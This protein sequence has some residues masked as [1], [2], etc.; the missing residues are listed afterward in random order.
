MPRFNSQ[1]KQIYS[2][3]R[4]KEEKVAESNWQQAVKA[5]GQRLIAN[6]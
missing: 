5:N 2:G 3:E 4:G 6:S 1:L